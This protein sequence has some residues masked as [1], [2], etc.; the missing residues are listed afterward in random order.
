MARFAPVSLLACMA[1]SS[2]MFFA[3][4]TGN[5][6]SGPT[7]VVLENPVFADSE[8]MELPALREGENVLRY[9][10]YVS[11]YNTETLIPDWVAYELLPEELE[12]DADRND[13][14]FS[15]DMTRRNMR[16]AKREDYRD[17]GWSKGHM[18]PAADF[19]W[20]SD[21]MG[22]SFLFVNCCPQNEYLNRKDW[23]YLERQV[24]RWAEEFGKVWVVTGPII[25]D[26]VYGTIGDDEV[27][28]P[29][30]FFKAVLVSSGGKYHSIAF[31]MGN[32]SSRYYLRD[33]SMSVNALEE[34]TGIDF[35]PALDDAV[36]DKVEDEVRLVFWGIK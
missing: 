19:R 1:L 13:H 5:P 4:G 2:C 32:D 36:E 26:N 15:M 11:S 35:F 17:S 30:A 6:A 27:V 23:E 3:P 25:G 28:I 14:V 9:S 21:V 33:C 34:E 10:A 22:E 12:G 31:V 18:A 8:Q 7:P 16:Q 20:D 24:R 29:D